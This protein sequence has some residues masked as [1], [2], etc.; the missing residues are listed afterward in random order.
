MSQDDEFREFVTVRMDRWRRT[1]F[2]LS[3]DWHAADDLVSIMVGKLYWH[4]AKVSRAGNPEAFAQRVLTRTWLDE[5]RRPWSRERA[6]AR[7]PEPSGSWASLGSSHS[8][9]ARVDDRAQLDELLGSLGPRQ[10]AVLVLRF[11]LNHSVEETADL[12]GIS[13]GTVKSQSARALEALRQLAA[14]G[15][16]R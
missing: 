4:W 5:R 11:Y 10:R 9:Q 12:L 13:V 15:D 8:P 2:L 3:R 16:Q 7:L 14:S 6:S 1:A